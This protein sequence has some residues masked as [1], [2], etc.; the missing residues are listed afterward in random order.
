LRRAARANVEITG[1][2]PDV[3]PFLRRA[4]VFLAPLFIGGGT[5]VKVLEALASGVPVVSTAVGCE[6]LE[7]VD[8]TSVLLADGPQA[9]A[10]AVLRVLEDPSLARSLSDGGREVGRR[11]DWEIIGECIDGFCSEVVKSPRPS[12]LASRPAPIRRADTEARL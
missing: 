6:G 9:F 3:R 11:Y 4:S 7:V 10:D 12:R 5:R 8:G 1:Y 2:V